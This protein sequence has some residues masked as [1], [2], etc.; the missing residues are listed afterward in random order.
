MHVPLGWGRVPEVFGCFTWVSRRVSYLPGLVWGSVAVFLSAET[1]VQSGM[2]NVRGRF[3]FDLVDLGRFQAAHI[4][5][6]RVRHPR[7][8]VESLNPNPLNPNPSAA[9]SRVFGGPPWPSGAVRPRSYT[10]RANFWRLSID[11][12]STVLYVT[13]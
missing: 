8:S 12:R 10:I 1:C 4:G 5:D 6:D 13:R 9:D 2:L 3:G 11:G 7:F